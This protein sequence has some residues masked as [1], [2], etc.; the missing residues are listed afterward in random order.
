MPKKKSASSAP[1]A[2][3]DGQIFV[4]ATSERDGVRC[5][6]HGWLYNTDGQCVQIPGEP[7][8]SELKKESI[9]LPAYPV[10]ELGGLIFAYF[11]AAQ[12]VGAAL[13]IFS[14]G[15]GEVYYHDPRLTEL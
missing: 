12:A 13:T 3:T 11:G 14:V 7:P 9:R 1:F 4:S 10:E 2:R 8:N 15:E 6:Y 5:R